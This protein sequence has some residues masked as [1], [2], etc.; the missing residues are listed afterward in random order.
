MAAN[1]S[2]TR[3]KEKFQLCGHKVLAAMQRKQFDEATLA[4]KAGVSVQTIRNY[5]KKSW[6]ASSR[7][8]ERVCAVLQLDPD[9]LRTNAPTSSEPHDLTPDSDSSTC[10]GNSF[11]KI[12]GVWTAE[13]QDLEVPDY[14][15][16]H[17]QPQPWRGTFVIKQ[18]RHR[19]SVSGKDRDGDAIQM[20]GEQFESGNWLRLTYEVRNLEKH[21]YGSAL[22]ECK[23]DGMKYEGIFL[24]RNRNKSQI[25]MVLAKVTIVKVIE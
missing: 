12:D 6:P 8:L 22:L 24:G 2:N 25:G 3:D 14:L 15:M 23:I 10:P 20:T 19:F 17:D 5:L 16:Y 21:Q 1:K 7:S 13:S 9:Q 11:I 4:R 18:D